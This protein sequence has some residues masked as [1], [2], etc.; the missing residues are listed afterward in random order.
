MVVV[1]LEFNWLKQIDVDVASMVP[2]FSIIS[3]NNVQKEGLALGLG[4]GAFDGF[5]FHGGDFRF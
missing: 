1:G 2:I 4:T 3:E 5:L